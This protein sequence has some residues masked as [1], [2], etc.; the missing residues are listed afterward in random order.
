[1]RLPW[2]S[3]LIGAIKESG[4]MF[5]RTQGIKKMRLKISVKACRILE[6]DLGNG[7]KIGWGKVCLSE[8]KRFRTTDD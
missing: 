3:G 1:M 5:Q 4:H 2:D 7:G 6:S 8:K